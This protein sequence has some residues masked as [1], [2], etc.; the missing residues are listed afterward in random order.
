MT[1]E[2]LTAI[3]DAHLVW[4]STSG[5]DGER[6]NLRG[7]DL[8][9]ARLGGA[10]LE[11]ADL[12]G[13]YLYGTN[14]E[15]AKLRNANLEGAYL[16]SADLEG[17]D[18]FNANLRLANV[19][20]ANL[21]GANLGEANLEAANLED[22]KL[23]VAYLEGANLKGANLEGAVLAGANLGS[24][25][26]GNA[27][28]KGA[29]LR[30]A[31]LRRAYLAGANFF[32]ADLDNANL[33]GAYLGGANLLRAHLGSANLEGANLEIALLKETDLQ[34]A[35]LKGAYLEDTDLQDANLEGADL[36]DAD[37]RGAN[38]RRARLGDA[39]LE[40]ANFDGA[41]LE[42]ANL[43]GT[44]LEKPFE[45]H[46]AVA[47]GKKTRAISKL[48]RQSLPMKAGAFK[49]LFPEEFE[50]IKAETKGADFTP[51]LLE[52]LVKKYG[53]VWSVS[54]GS[55]PGDA[56]RFCPNANDVLQLNID[57]SDPVYTEQQKKNLEAVK[58]VSARSNHPVARGK[59]YFTI[60]WVRY[61]QF[62]DRILV[63]EV[64]S[65]VPGVRKGLKDPD[66]RRRLERAGVS[67]DEL[68]ET[69]ALLA[70]FADRFYEDALGLVFDMAEE[71]GKKVEMF[72]YVQKQQFGS[73]RA[74]YTDLPRSM[75]MK[76]GPSEAM[77][78]IGQVWKYTPNRKRKT[79]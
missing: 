54:T 8:G 50:R 46:P 13:A 33:Q 9:G 22:A 55:Y 35:N 51:E 32:V 43:E 53:I 38:L 34:G 24:A 71:Q 76:L 5:R 2:E 75:G 29:D 58:E 40:G 56:Q 1:N 66:F 68:E 26:L 31:V 27:K 64:Q 49:K 74:V 23:G 57:M 72:D 61:C 73:P 25:N 18:L 69:L 62:P 3:L 17:A 42:G 15:G 6:A 44:I 16:G 52:A 37:L 39:R 10:R 59:N 14:L 12:D 47:K 70:P 45:A 21:I 41:D 60:G 36:R 7:T 30:E 67:P 48:K 28:L 77:P 20:G 11:G 63:E 4:L 65:D 19:Y 79:R 78:W